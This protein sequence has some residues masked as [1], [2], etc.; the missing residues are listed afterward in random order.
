M[1]PQFSIRCLM[2][3]SS[4]I[5]SCAWNT[6]NRFFLCLSLNILWSR[7]NHTSW[8][9]RWWAR[10]YRSCLSDGWQTWTSCA[11]GRTDGSLSATSYCSYGIGKIVP[12]DSQILLPEGFNHRLHVLHGLLVVSKVLIDLLRTCFHAVVTSENILDENPSRIIQQGVPWVDV[13]Y[14][15]R[16]GSRRRA[17]PR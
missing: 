5:C 7:Y 8:C 16:L 6:S 15:I 1:L 9:W 17:G 13:A 11:P 2:L 14:L 4:R 3:F 10:H 12:G